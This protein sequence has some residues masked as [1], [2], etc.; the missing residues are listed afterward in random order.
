MRTIQLLT[1]GLLCAGFFTIM[2]ATAKADMNSEISTAADHAKL[3]S[4][5]A[6]I[7]EAQLHLHHT[8]NCLVGAKDHDYNAKAGD[9]CTGMGNG[10]ITDATSAKVKKA[11][12]RAEAHVKSAL[13]NKHLATVRKLAGKIEAELVKIK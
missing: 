6:N 1:L 13:K 5:A 9:P 4:T 10:A 3:S 11:L 2:P 8:L 12:E 7:E